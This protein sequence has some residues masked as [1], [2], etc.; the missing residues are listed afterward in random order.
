MGCGRTVVKALG[1]AIDP[2]GSILHDT[3]GFPYS[4]GGQIQR[5]ATPPP[6]PTPASKPSPP[7]ASPPRISGPQIV[8][9]PAVPAAT[10][11]PRFGK[12]PA[13]AG[14]AADRTKGLLRPPGPGPT[15]LT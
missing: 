11:P 12:E 2:V 15:L 4:P 13:G 9:G 5:L 3:T 8:R 14:A 10:P 7:R 6:I 1:Y